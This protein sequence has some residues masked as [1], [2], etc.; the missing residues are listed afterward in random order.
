MSGLLHIYDVTD[1]VIRWTVERRAEPNKLGV[2]SAQDLENGLDH[3]LATGQ[4]F[5]RILFETHGS[6]GCLW[7]QNSPVGPSQLVKYGRFSRLTTSGAR[8]YFNGCNVGDGAEGWKF[9]NFAA[10][11]LIVPHT[12]KVVAQTRV[13]FGNFYNGHVVHLASDT[14]AIE[15]M[16]DGQFVQT[17]T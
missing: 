6:P 17:T 1:P 7:F 15:V 2:I 13:G 12:G 16:A 10:A 5:D 4:T 11:A 14:R 9:L 3:L 8:I